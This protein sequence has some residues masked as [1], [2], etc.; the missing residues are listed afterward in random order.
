MVEV[1]E[2]EERTRRREIGRGKKCGRG[3]VTR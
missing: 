3:D 1:E 2:K